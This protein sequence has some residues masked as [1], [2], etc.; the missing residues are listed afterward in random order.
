MGEFELEK[1]SNMV[2]WLL[3]GAGEQGYLTT[4]QI[5]EALPEVED[6]LEQ[7]E[8]LLAILQD[9][10]IEVYH[11]VADA[12]EQRAATQGENGKEDKHHKD[13]LDLS[14]I[15]ISDTLGLYFKEMS[16]V[17]LLTHEEEIALARQMERGH[18]AR[19]ELGRDGHNHEERVR[20]EQLIEQGEEARQHL[21]KANTRLVVSVARRYRGLGLSF[22]DLIQAGNLA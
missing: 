21:I 6:N 1:Q 12:K 10:G 16:H 9:R 3:E 4:D 19:T 20:L 17:P 8:D 7:L 22:L 15:P 13:M 11:S 5:L 2:Q 14:R 18:E